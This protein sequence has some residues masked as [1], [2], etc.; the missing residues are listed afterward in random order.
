[1]EIEYRDDV[2][3][4][5][6][7][8]HEHLMIRR[9]IGSYLGDAACLPP[10]RV[11]QDD[12]PV[13]SFYVDSTDESPARVSTSANSARI[14]AECIEHGWLP[15]TAEQ[16]DIAALVAWELREAALELEARQVGLTIP[17]VFAPEDLA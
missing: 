7:A 11:E 9:A 4:F 5:L 2:F 13:L 14:L 6:P 1:M 3:A 17:D 16:A 10:D 12:L 15:P 8:P